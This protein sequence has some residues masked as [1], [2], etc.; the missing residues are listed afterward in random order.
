MTIWTSALVDN[1]NK[2]ICLDIGAKRI[3]V[4]VSD[5][6]G[7][8]ALPVQVLNRESL[9]KDLRKIE[10]LVLNH[11]ARIL[12]VGYPKKM[13]GSLGSQAAVVDKFIAKMSPRIKVSILR[14]DAGVSS[15]RS[16]TRTR[17]ALI[18]FSP[19]NVRAPSILVRRSGGD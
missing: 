4:A 13:D 19:S 10:D 15:S 8:L 3:G 6:A 12:V 16:P 17:T 11:E 5:P 1:K 2:I 18:A 7:V 9:E 14:W